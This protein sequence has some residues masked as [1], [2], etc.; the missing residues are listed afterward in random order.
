M[1]RIT[2]H[3]DGHGLNESIEIVADEPDESGASHHY[4]LN[5]GGVSVAAIQFQKGPRNQPESTPGI[6]EAALYA[7]LIDRLQGFQRG[8]YGCRENALQLTKLEECLHWTKARAD[9]RARRG[10]LGRAV[11]MILAALLCA[12]AAF[13]RPVT[14]K[15]DYAPTLDVT[16]KLGTETHKI[17]VEDPQEPAARRCTRGPGSEMDVCTRR[18]DG[19]SVVSCSVG[20]DKATGLMTMVCE[21]GDLN[22]F[23]VCSGATDASAPG[24]TW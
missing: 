3:H 16:P 11:P 15:G 2:N 20:T 4:T 13:G 19:R 5:M 14:P 6:T 7:V 10:V 1:R 8:A 23:A 12:C 18:C 22:L 17:V 21:C 24:V 9:E